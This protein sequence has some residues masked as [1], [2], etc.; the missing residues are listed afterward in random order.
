MLQRMHWLELVANH[1]HKSMQN[2]FQVHLAVSTGLDRV[3]TR[4]WV[5]CQ[6]YVLTGMVTRALGGLY[7]G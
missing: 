2:V 3:K 7:F 6:K 4:C 1:D 5:H